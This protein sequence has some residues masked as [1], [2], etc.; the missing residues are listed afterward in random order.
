[1]ALYAMVDMT[2]NGDNL[3]RVDNV[4]QAT[5]KPPQINGYRWLTDSDFAP[6]AMVNI[7]F[8]W[9]GSLPA[10]FIEKPDPVIPA[11]AP[12]TQTEALNAALGALEAARIAV[13]QALAKG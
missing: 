2:D 12:A 1:M 3:F 9:T 11:D 10:E 8:Y 4:F 13:E 6:G 5:T 7:G